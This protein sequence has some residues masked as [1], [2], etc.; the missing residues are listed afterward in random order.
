MLRNRERLT[1]IAME[2]LAA[3]GHRAQQCFSEASEIVIFG[4]MSVGLERLASDIDLLCIGRRD[5]TLKTHS[6]DLIALK[7]ETTTSAGW[8]ES[9]LASHIAEYGTWL[10]GSPEWC[11]EV[12]IGQ[13]A[14]SEKRRRIAAFMKALP[15]SW[16]GLD[17]VF[18]VK[19]SVKLRRETQRLL[20]LE[21]G[22]SV[23]PTRVLDDCWSGISR[24]P[25]EVHDRLSRL[26]S[27]PSNNF[28]QDLFGRIDAHF[29]MTR[30]HRQSA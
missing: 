12:Q 6:L 19:Y 21:K 30:E 7:V 5:F 1:Q 15:N 27:C 29:E 2:R 14:I 16:S 4:S 24:S 9:E 23:P 17:E 8:L 28:I 20:L 11:S 3:S 13:N 26:A 10:K 18:R 22:V 25:C